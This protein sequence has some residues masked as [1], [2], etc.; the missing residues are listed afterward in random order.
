MRH[1]I[2]TL[3]IAAVVSL[4]G[5][6]GGPTE[7]LTDADALR[8]AAEFDHIADSL[9]AAGMPSMNC[10]SRKV[11]KALNAAGRISPA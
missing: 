5:C 7:T 9:T 10:L 4:T 2:R 3:A 11:P 1:V 8:A 6:A